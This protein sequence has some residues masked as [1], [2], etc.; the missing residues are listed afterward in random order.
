MKLIKLPKLKPQLWL[1]NKINAIFRLNE[2]KICYKKN[3][4]IL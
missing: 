2:S 1:V 3:V 4:N